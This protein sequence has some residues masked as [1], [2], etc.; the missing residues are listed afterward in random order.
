MT[1]ERAR[2]RRAL[3]LFWGPACSRQPGARA[4]DGA[5][6]T[7]SARHDRATLRRAAS[8]PRIEPYPRE[9]SGGVGRPCSPVGFAPSA[10]SLRSSL[11][12]SDRAHLVR[13]VI[14]VAAVVRLRASDLSVGGG[15]VGR[16]RCLLESLGS[17]GRTGC[18]ARR[19]FGPRAAG[20]SSFL[21]A[22][23]I[24]GLA[25]ASGAARAGTGG[26][27][28]SALASGRRRAIA[29]PGTVSGSGGPGP[30]G[31]DGAGAASPDGAPG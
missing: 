31:G 22:R 6:D 23:A 28:G 17:F 18:G 30:R 27:D 10:P 26:P 21:T 8:S 24:V 25:A 13:V 19:T 15:H 11:I 2:T 3:S 14:P 16:R 5:A 29:R 20:G 12:G 1:G 9:R 4:D 7:G